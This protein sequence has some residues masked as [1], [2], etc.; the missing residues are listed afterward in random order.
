MTNQVNNLENINL[1][2]SVVD[3]YLVTLNTSLLP[4]DVVYAASI[5][6]LPDEYAVLAMTRFIGALTLKPAYDEPQYLDLC[7]RYMT[8][9]RESILD[10]VTGFMNRKGLFDWAEQNFNPF[11]Y[12][13]GVFAVDLEDFRSV[14]NSLGHIKGD[15][16]LKLACEYISSQIRVP[17]NNMPKHSG[18][19]AN[20]SH[21][22]KDV[23]CLARIGGDEILFVMNFNGL[24]LIIAE[25][26]VKRV[27]EE[28]DAKKITMYGDDGLVSRYFGF[29]TGA[30]ISGPHNRMSF[31]ESIKRADNL[32]RIK[33]RSSAARHAD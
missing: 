15:E 23:M 30:V 26:V 32:E 8:L 19:L 9:R 6:D 7:M 28:L 13:Y 1:A 29:R 20:R 2:L 11:I 17:K 27:T 16:A 5:E 14:N 31:T 21:D 12:T 3:E 33:K 4:N 18:E 24:D 25:N 22:K 10:S